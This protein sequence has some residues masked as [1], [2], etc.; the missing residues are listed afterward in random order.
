MNHLIKPFI[1]HRHYFWSN[2]NIPNVNLPT[3]NIRGT[4]EHY[5][6]MYG[7]DY[8]NLMQKIK[9]QL[10]RIVFIQNLGYISLI[11]LL[12]RSRNF[13]M[14]RKGYFSELKA[15]K[16]LYQLWRFIS[17]QSCNWRSSGLYYS[18]MR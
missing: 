7:F 14:T 12:K 3:L 10:L 18:W 6:R 1:A 16:S 11:W 15:R 4:K 13:R 8:L 5:G 9:G 17:C 2:F